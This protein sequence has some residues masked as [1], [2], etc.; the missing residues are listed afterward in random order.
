[1]LKLLRLMK[2]Y[3]RSVA[4]VL[5]LAF[6]QSLANL[7]PPRLMADIVD[8]GIVRGDVRTIL[9]IGALMLLVTIAGTACAIAGSFFASKSA[10]GFGRIVRARVFERV[11]RFSLHDFDRFSSASL[12]TRTTNDTTQIQQVLI[13]VLSM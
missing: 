6:F 10:I 4:A 9:S 8:K 13:M 2:P 7:Y 12:I 3:R 5:I 1:M 11:E